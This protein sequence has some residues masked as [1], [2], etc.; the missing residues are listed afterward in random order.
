VTGAHDVSQRVSQFAQSQWCFSKGFDKSNPLGP[1]FVP[2]SAI[3]D[4]TKI[5]VK[6]ELNGKV[7]QRSNIS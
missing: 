3:S 6:G 2:T 4:L 1:V 5:E 7:V